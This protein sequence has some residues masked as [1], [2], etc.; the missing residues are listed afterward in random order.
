M[1]I[2]MKQMSVDLRHTGPTVP[3]DQRSDAP[4]LAAK[5]I[6]RHFFMSRTALALG[7]GLLGLI[8]GLLIDGGDRTQTIQAAAPVTTAAELPHGTASVHRGA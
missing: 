2:D 3:I 7:A 6:T 1:T 5:A 4:L 8:F